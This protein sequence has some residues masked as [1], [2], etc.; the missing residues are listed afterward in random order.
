VEIW[1]GPQESP[2]KDGT[3]TNTDH[4]LVNL[5]TG[6][7]IKYSGLL[8]TMIDRYGFYEGEKTNYRLDPKDIA[9]VADF[10]PTPS[11]DPIVQLVQNPDASVEIKTSEQLERVIN[12]CLVKVDVL[13]GPNYQII[14]ETLE[15]LLKKNLRACLK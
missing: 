1:R 7:R 10:I 8:P 6:A 9:K 12:L 14:P 2:F 15:A 3:Q 13:S 5:K 11:D 4:V